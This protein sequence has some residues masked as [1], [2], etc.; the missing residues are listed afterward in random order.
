MVVSRYSWP[1]SAPWAPRRP[2]TVFVV[3][4]DGVLTDGTFLYGVDGKRYKRFGPDDA[5]ALRLLSSTVQIVVV[6]ADRRGYGISDARVSDMGLNLFLVPSSERLNWVTDRFGL[7]SLAYMGDSFQDAPLLSSA[8][9]GLCPRNAHPR[10]K[11]SANVVTKSSGGNRAVT[12]ACA[13]IA[14]INKLA[15]AQLL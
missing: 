6:S 1:V 15:I 3:D 7:E 5:D 12:E 13:V 14:R 10:A 2:I 11:R 4:V 8:A 9:L